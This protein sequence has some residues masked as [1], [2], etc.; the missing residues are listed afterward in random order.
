[1]QKV[2]WPTITVNRL[3]STP[4]TWVKVSLIAIPVTIPGSAIGMMTRN[5]IVSRPKKRWR[6]TA[7]E[8]SVP[9]TIAIA[10]AAQAALI[11]VT[12]ASR[13]P[14][15]STAFWNQSSGETVGRPL[16]RLA[17]VERVDQ[18]HDQRDVDERQR[19]ADAEREGISGSASRAS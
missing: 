15:F 13:A 12:N 19:Q 18:D 2:A 8:A 1:M 14:E 16:E 7:S 3:R 11:E 6:E 4:S 10:V 17:R 5:E 9:S